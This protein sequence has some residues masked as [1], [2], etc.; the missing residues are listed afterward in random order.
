MK[1]PFQ[2]S[3]RIFFLFIA[4][5]LLFSNCSKTETPDP[6]PVAPIVGKWIL[7]D[8]KGKFSTNFGGT[9][10]NVIN[11]TG[12]AADSFTFLA[13]N[14]FASAGNIKVSSISLNLGTGTYKLT[15]DE[16]RIQAKDD[17]FKESITYFKATITG[18]VLSLVLNKDLY[19]KGL[20][21]SP[22]YVSGTQ[23]A[24]INELDLTLT[25]KK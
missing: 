22:G 7:T 23:E 10:S 17:L 19:F 4:M 5:V 1:T 14:T 20:K 15:N 18:N 21:E 13:D 25:F 24:V 2:V 6:Q 8:I 11:Q 16:L 12:S 3:S 9:G